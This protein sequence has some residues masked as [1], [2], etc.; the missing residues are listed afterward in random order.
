MEAM[1][2]GHMQ[3]RVGWRKKGREQARKWKTSIWK[4]FRKDVSKDG[5]IEDNL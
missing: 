4:G 3:E 5:R 2:K 1:K